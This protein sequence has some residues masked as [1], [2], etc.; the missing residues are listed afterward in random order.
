M[1]STAEASKGVKT[2]LPVRAE[3]A[4]SCREGTEMKAR[5][6]GI[7]TDRRDVAIVAN[8]YLQAP[9]GI[10]KRT[11]DKRTCSLADTS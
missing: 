5:A 4:E 11:K 6:H 2:Q 9:Q 7:Q 3:S 8:F 1:T 10:V